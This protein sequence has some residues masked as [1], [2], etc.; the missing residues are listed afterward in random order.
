M[1]G[2]RLSFDVDLVA[3]GDLRGGRGFAGGTCCQPGPL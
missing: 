2:R 1:F 3:R